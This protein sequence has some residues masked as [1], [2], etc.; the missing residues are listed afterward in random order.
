M[1]IRDRCVCVCVCVCV[2]VYVCTCVY[3]HCMCVGVCACACACVCVL[4]CV[5]VCVCACAYLINFQSVSVK[6]LACSTIRLSSSLYVLA[7]LLSIATSHSSARFLL[8]QKRWKSVIAW[9]VHLHIHIY[10]L[11]YV[12]KEICVHVHAPSS[13]FLVNFVLC[14]KESGHGYLYSH[15]LYVTS[16]GYW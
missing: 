5:S 11:T 16:T 6:I 12:T 15:T 8:Q 2:H 14:Y 13:C 10:I 1:C 7:F 9:Q 3:V 4:V